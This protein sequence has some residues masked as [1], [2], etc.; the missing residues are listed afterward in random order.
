MSAQSPARSNA[1]SSGNDR[2]AGTNAQAAQ[3][4]QLGQIVELQDLGLHIKEEEKKDEPRQ[5][6]QT[7]VGEQ[8]DRSILEQLEAPPR[9]V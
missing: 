5:V 6:D 2:S 3:Q 7:A 4:Q 8:A 1:R 9:G